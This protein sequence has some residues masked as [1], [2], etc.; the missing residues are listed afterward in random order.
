MEKRSHIVGRE[1]EIA[2]AG[3]EKSSNIAD[4]IGDAGSTEIRDR[5]ATEQNM[6]KTPRFGVHET[7]AAL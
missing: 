5:F 6:E 2:H 1:Y 7:G 3:I 4:E